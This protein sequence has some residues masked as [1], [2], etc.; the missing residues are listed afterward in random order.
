MMSRLV[1]PNIVRGIVLSPVLVPLQD[2]INRNKLNRV[3]LAQVC[4][5]KIVI[6][7][8]VNQVGNDRFA[9]SVILAVLLFNISLGSFQLFV[10]KTTN[11]LFGNLPVRIAIFNHLR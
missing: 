1:S 11:W 6:H 10:A 7:V 3:F 5:R 2:L 9:D 8:I 4:W